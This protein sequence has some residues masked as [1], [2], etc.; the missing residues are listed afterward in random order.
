MKTIVS[1]IVALAANNAIGKDN[2]LLCYV[3][4]DLKRFKELT[5]GH[6]VIMGRL[7]FESL[8]NGALPNRRNIV[9][10]SNP[11]LN[12]AACETFLSLEDAIKAVQGEEEVF[13]IGGGMVYTQALEFADRLYLTQIEA[14]L[15]GDTFLS[16]IDYNLWHETFK[17]FHEPSEKCP[18]SFS[19]VNY[20]RK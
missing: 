18:Y 16:K 17:E 8:P 4:G 7:T 1:I 12:L 11:D 6:T 3:P 5:S 15:D 14:N 19:F 2:Q 13:I 9:I 20:Q 10:S